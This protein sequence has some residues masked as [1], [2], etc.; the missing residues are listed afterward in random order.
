MTPHTYDT[1][2]RRTRA[3]PFR[4]APAEVHCWCINLDVPPETSARLY[5]TLTADEHDRVARFRFR[6]DRFVVAH[7][8]L[9]DL[10]GR[11]LQIQP[12][13]IRYVFNAFGKP[14]LSPE[15]GGRLKFNLSHSAGLALVAI[16]AESDVGVDLEYLRAQSDYPDIARRF[17]SAA[18]ADDLGAVPNHRY[19]EA[20]IGCWTKKEAYV[21]A[22]G[23]GLASPANDITGATRW[24]IYALQPAPGY[25]GALVMEGHGWRLSQW[26]WDMLQA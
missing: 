14:Y 1:S 24:S 17:F 4:L 9:R 7:G 20:F 10:L 23:C 25:I 15:F 3:T 22:R 11:Y 18:E 8:V 16:A 2:H 26:Q 12:E 21:K 5:T 6:S 19:A 13:R